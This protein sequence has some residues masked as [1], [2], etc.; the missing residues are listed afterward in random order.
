[1]AADEANGPKHPAPD[2]D[3]PDPKRRAGEGLADGAL[4]QTI[5]PGNATTP[6]TGSTTGSGGTGGC[7]TPLQATPQKPMYQ[8]E[9]ARKAA[10]RKAKSDAME[11]QLELDSTSGAVARATSVAAEIAAA[12]DGNDMDE[13]LK[14]D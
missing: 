8:N 4:V 6:A 3:A 2:P 14:V 7:A 1:M 12:A 9:A 5:L 11:A 10:E 13:D